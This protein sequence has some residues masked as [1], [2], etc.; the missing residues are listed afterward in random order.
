MPL[1]LSGALPLPL[2]LRKSGSGGLKSRRSREEKAPEGCPGVGGR[3]GVV[4]GAP[5]GS[6]PGVGFQGGGRSTAS[7]VGRSGSA[8]RRGVLLRGVGSG[9]VLGKSGTTYV[10]AEPAG[11][12]GGTGAAGEMRSGGGGSRR[13]GR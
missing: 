9:V 7:S 5:T 6:T 8:S 11:K 12:G 10:E 1:P 2:P 4:P 13:C 3:R